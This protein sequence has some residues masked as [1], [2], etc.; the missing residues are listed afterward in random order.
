MRSACTRLG[1]I[2]LGSE[3]RFEDPI[4]L[5]ADGALQILEAPDKRAASKDKCQPSRRDHLRHS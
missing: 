1:G 5:Q 3:E 4:R 2:P